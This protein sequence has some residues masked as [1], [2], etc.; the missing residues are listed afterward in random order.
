MLSPATIQPPKQHGTGPKWRPRP[1][2]VR[3]PADAE[4]RFAAADRMLARLIERPGLD[5]IVR[6]EPSTTAPID[7]AVAE[8][9]VAAYRLGNGSDTAHGFLHRVLYRINRMML[10]WFD[11]L[12]RY[13]N[14]RSPYLHRLRAIIER[15]WQ[16]S[17]LADISLPVMSA[18]A[19]IEALRARA[20]ADVDPPPSESGRYFRD[21][22]TL[23]AY[24]RLLEIASLDGLVEAS[25]LSRTLGGVGDPIH[26]TMT[27]LLL[28][29]YGG[30]R[31]ARK[32]ST[33]FQT[34]L[35]ALGMD[36]TPEA[37]FDV[38]PWEVLAGIN[39]S[40]LLSDRRRLYLRY[41]GGLL[42]TETSVPSAFRCYLA[43]AERLGLPPAATTYW[44]L[45]IKEDARHGPW[46]LD[47]VAIP[48]ARRYPDDAWEL[49]LGYDQ[50]RMMSA[51]AGDAIARAC[52]AVA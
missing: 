47:E 4:S 2:I 49:V 14:D 15:A 6:R 39:H 21:R 46:M 52:A 30:G 50:Q 16:E 40:F 3:D 43:A 32:H 10:F 18:T 12:R 45:H 5:A 42:Y 20:A 26:G 29:E 27:R 13:D 28:E 11:D 44:T 25:Q 22:A 35:E 41:V 33:Y 36:A 7:A 48:L 23:R 1:S 9:I 19:V 38:V 51:R 8:A 17:E 31:L 37:H 24:R 34:M